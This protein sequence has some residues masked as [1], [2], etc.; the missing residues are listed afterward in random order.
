M[1]K[2]IEEHTVTQHCLA[3]YAQTD[4]KV[5]IGGGGV[6]RRGTYFRQIFLYVNRL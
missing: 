3:D 1:K 2:S 6:R 5:S 4:V